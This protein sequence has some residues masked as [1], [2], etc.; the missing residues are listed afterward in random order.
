MLRGKVLE[1]LFHQITPGRNG[2][3]IGVGDGGMSDRIDGVCTGF[4]CCGCY[5][6]DLCIVDVDR[7]IHGGQGVGGNQHT[8]GRW[9]NYGCTLVSK[10]DQFKNMFDIENM[11]HVPERT[12]A[13]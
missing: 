8:L 3:G 5:E 10:F 9:Y 6:V 13:K 4:A 1:T 7:I 12:L 11:D 2:I